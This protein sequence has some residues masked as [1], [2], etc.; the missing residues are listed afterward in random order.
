MRVESVGDQLFFTTVRIDAVAENDAACSGTGFLF[1]HKVI[2]PSAVTA[3]TNPL[4]LS[5]SLVAWLTLALL[6]IG[7]GYFL[8][9]M[10]K[11]ELLRPAA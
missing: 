6:S 3:A 1:A 5:N 2:V 9:R 4:A 10:P 11:A 7:A 8:V